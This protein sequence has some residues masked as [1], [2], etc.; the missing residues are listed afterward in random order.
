M[1]KSHTSFSNRKKNYLGLLVRKTS[2]L[3]PQEGDNVKMAKGELSDG[4]YIGLWAA[5]CVLMSGYCC[6]HIAKSHDL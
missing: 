2:H 1:T 6:V 5:K 4:N 3:E